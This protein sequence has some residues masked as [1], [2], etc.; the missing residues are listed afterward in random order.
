MREAPPKW[1]SNVD[2]SRFKEV[3]QAGRDHT[4]T[5][6]EELH[7]ILGLD[8]GT[9]STK[10]V[11]RLPYEAG[12]PTIAI[13]APVPCR[14]DANPY[15][16]QTVLWLS[17]KDTFFAWPEP[18]GTVFDRLKQGLIH[19]RSETSILVSGVTAPINRAQA[20]TAYLALVVRY[21][22]GWLRCNRP[23]LLRERKPIWF[24][25]VG[26]PTASYDDAELA[27]PYRRIAAAALQLAKCD[28]SVTRT[29][30]QVF[31]EHEEVI[32]A[33]ESRDAAEEL[34]VAVIPEAAAAMTSFAKSTRDADGLYLSVDVGAMTLDA[35]MFRL[36][37]D[38]SDNDCYA[39][40]AAQVRPLGVE[41]FH[42]FLSENKTEMEFTEQCDR[43]LRAV[44]WTTKLI[45]DPRSPNWT[46]GNDVPVFLGGGGAV[47]LLHRKTLESVG[48]WLQ[49]HASNEGIRVLEL[50]M[51][52]SLDSPEPDLQFGRMAVAWG[53][54]LPPTDIGQYSLPMTLTTFH[55]RWFEMLVRTLCPRMK[56]ELGRG[57]RDDGCGRD[58]R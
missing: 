45:R 19:G 54:S 13:P 1:I 11:V 33:G 17:D 21:A 50:K 31:L 10:V 46:A 53:L 6:G 42:W 56:S 49:H 22:M 35:C 24:I 12:E 30:V 8:F 52:D 51:P 34:G 29:A 32:A 38:R 47:N 2:K 57:H 5:A 23:T 28:L 3:L 44:I 7:V 18:G 37:R 16:W 43:M 39:F 26:M 58:S 36:H 15:L 9:S 27:K 41:A 20:G 48:P 55:C 14:S 4:D 25:N 40:M